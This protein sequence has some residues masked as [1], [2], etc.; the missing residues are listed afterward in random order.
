VDDR[1]G[2]KGVFD[3]AL[4]WTPDVNSLGSP[5]A[6]ATNAPSIFTAV[7][8]QLGFRLDARKGPVDVLVIDHVEKPTSD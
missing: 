1:T 7:R 4:D 2:L 8:E 6:S 3:F 5:A